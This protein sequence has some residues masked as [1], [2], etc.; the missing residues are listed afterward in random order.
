MTSASRAPVVV[1]LLGGLAVQGAGAGDGNSALQ[2]KQVALLAYL[3][4]SDDETFHRR[5]RLAAL[6]WPELDQAH[7]RAALR[8]AL[9]HL[10]AHLGHE[11]VSTRGHEE[12]RLDPA[13]VWC[14][15]RELILRAAERTE[16]ADEAAVSLYAGELLPGLHVAEAGE[17]MQWLDERRLALRSL[18]RDCALRLAG[19][20]RGRGEARQAGQWAARA[21]GIVPLE[22][23]PNRLLIELLD[24]S[25]DAPAA[26]D[27]YRR[28]AE[29]LAR[30][31]EVE[32]DDETRAI[33]ARVRQRLARVRDDAPVE[34]NPGDVPS[35][36]V[37]IAREPAS[38]ARE[39]AI[40]AG[41][42]KSA[43]AH[44][45]RPAVT[46]VA[47]F[48]LALALVAIAVIRGGR[49]AAAGDTTAEVPT[50][51]IERVRAISTS[52]ELKTDPA[53]SPDG[54][55][56]AFATGPLGAMRIMVQPVEGGR[57]VTLTSVL[58]GDHRWPAWS[59]DGER[60]LFIRKDSRPDAPG[61][62]WVVPAR[63]G[64]PSLMFDTLAHRAE[65]AGQ[66]WMLTLAWSPD[67]R[68]I[69]YADG[70]S[71]LVRDIAGG[72]PV[73]VV[74]EPH[75][76]SPSFSPDGKRLAYV[77]GNLWGP[78]TFSIASSAVCVV[79]IA[80]RRPACITDSTYANS[81]PIW[82]PDGRSVLFV[83]NAGG[84]HDVWEQRVEHDGRLPA[85]PVRL[86]TGLGVAGLALS[87]DGS[88]GV[89]A[90]RR[91]RSRI[92]MIDMRSANE[93]SAPRARVI[94]A[95]AQG[96]EGL[97]LS[98]DGE[99]LVY[100]SDRGGNS[101]IWRMPASGGQAERLT[102][103]PAPDFQP[104]WSPDGS[105]IAYYS[106]RSG[107]RDVRLMS[108]TGAR[109]EAVTT[110]VMQEGYPDWAPDG[111]ALAFMTSWG[112][113]GL[114]FRVF[115]DDRGRWSAPTAIAHDGSP[116]QGMWPRWSPDRRW[117]L[118]RRPDLGRARDAGASLWL[119]P[120][121]GGAPR[122]LIG[123][124]ELG[125][126]VENAVWDGAG[127]IIVHTM[128]ADSG[129]AFWSMPLDGAAPSLLLR[130]GDP[131][132]RPRRS[133][134]ATDGRRLFVTMADDETALWSMVIRMR[135]APR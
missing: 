51:A 54:A 27:A 55:M 105:E 11:V 10:R 65:E 62:M 113:P 28:W 77:S 63:G 80:E 78:P 15:A 12:V 22:E 135:A 118:Y 97:D 129:S 40:D 116:I 8:K 3:A 110:G 29:L 71:I 111:R 57:A 49:L 84:E 76:H 6:L 56:L 48:A 115:R 127:R 45:S 42:G 66:W 30:E 94:T 16:A 38:S 14:D 5:D 4:V 32:P 75:V 88:R 60:I 131:A 86:T 21:T 124:R 68:H 43:G 90:V 41:N 17:F 73:R 106:L 81:S 130:L 70:E 79:R 2:S 67:G 61:A 98:P 100:D 23:E 91:L 31:L 120:T 9:H 102:R 39:W 1:R 117:I 50:I 46:M 112:S 89:Y 72:P 109:D 19:A 122:R 58:D 126:N 52:P 85:A 125:A 114:M 13:A 121:A 59:P 132:L 107:Q 36:G 64:V 83:S 96:I 82:L 74:R 99:W 24:E 101:D 53:I 26:L 37:Q 25:G 34:K 33:V 95:E 18:A 87:R 103:D 104:R 108:A 7:A 93:S 35:I 123:K 133:E 20:H 92:W 69:A 47:F 44:S 119:V 134:F 128:S